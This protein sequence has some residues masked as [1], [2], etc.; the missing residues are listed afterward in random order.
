MVAAIKA[1]NLDVGQS[2]YPNRWLPTWE[3]ELPAIFVYTNNES[4]DVH[5][6]APREVKRS[7][8]IITEI[9]CKADVSLDDTLDDL[10]EQVENLIAA[11]PQLT[12]TA[13]DTFLESSDL[14]L[15]TEGDALMGSL[16]ITW[17]VVWYKYMPADLTATLPDFKTVDAKTSLGG[18]QA[19]ADQTQQTI[20]VQI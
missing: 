14:E 10:S 3:T 9:I 5:S 15:F 1:A 13:D 19:D 7:T 20:T 17:S 2:V 18:E 11:N 16:K 6:I 8:K 12:D 4:V